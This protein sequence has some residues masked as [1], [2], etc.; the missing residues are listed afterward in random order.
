MIVDAHAHACGEYVTADAIKQKL[1]SCGCDKVILTPGQNG[2]R[3]TYALKNI[4]KAFI[5]ITG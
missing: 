1:H 5:R 4:R 3:T 2:S